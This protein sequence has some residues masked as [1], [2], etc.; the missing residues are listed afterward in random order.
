MHRKWHICQWH[1]KKAKKLHEIFVFLNFGHFESFQNYTL[2]V[3]NNY[4]VTNISG[5][6]WSIESVSA[7][8]EN[9]KD[10]LYC[11]TKIL[12]LSCCVLVDLS[13]ENHIYC[14]EYSDWPV[15]IHS[16]PPLVRAATLLSCQ[17]LAR[18]NLNQSLNPSTLTNV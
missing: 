9:N 17:Y 12:C 11:L 8:W 1:A 16:T 18:I 5:H 14:C 13:S 6:L 4:C 15:N 3:L 2:E 7:K 10:K